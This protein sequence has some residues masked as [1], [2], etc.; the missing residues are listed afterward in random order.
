MIFLFLWLYQSNIV[1]QYLISSESPCGVGS[2]CFLKTSLVLY[3]LRQTAL[4]FWALV[5]NHEAGLKT[6]RHEEMWKD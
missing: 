4:L 2:H 3:E 6:G 5:I 1:W